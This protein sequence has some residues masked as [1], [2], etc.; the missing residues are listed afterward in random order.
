MNAERSADSQSSKPSKQPDGHQTMN[1]DDQRFHIDEHN[2]PPG[3]PATPAE[4]TSAPL[5]QYEFVMAADSSSQIRWPRKHDGAGIKRVFVGPHFVGQGSTERT[6]SRQ[7]MQG[8]TA[9]AI[10]AGATSTSQLTSTVQDDSSTDSD[11]D[12][13]NG[14]SQD[15][16]SRHKRRRDQR[17]RLPTGE[18][19]HA[20]SRKSS[21]HKWV[22]ESFEIGGDVREAMARRQRRRRRSSES[23]A[24]RIKDSSTFVTARTHQP[25]AAAKYQPEQP[26]P[27]VESHLPPDMAHG[28]L[29]RPSD[30]PI[31]E[32]ASLS[33]A[34][35]PEELA[36]TPDPNVAVTSTRSKH[37]I[38]SGLGNGFP[39]MSTT[40]A[41]SVRSAPLPRP[42]IG[43]AKTSEE[44]PRKA[45][46]KFSNH[47]DKAPRLVGDLPPVPAE[48]VLARPVPDTMVPDDVQM[49]PP[50]PPRRRDDILAKERM[51]CRVDWTVREDLPDL[52]DEH[53]ARKFPTRHEG[54]EEFGV[55][56]RRNRVEL[57]TE[58][59]NPAL[60]LMAGKKKLKHV[61]P[62]RKTQTKLS[63]YSSVDGIFC[64]TH[65]ASATTV[66]SSASR[67]STAT[68]VKVDRETDDE[69]DDVS[70]PWWRKS[71]TKA[72]KR[73]YVHFRHSGTSVYIF[74]AKTMSV[75][76]DWMWQLFIKLGGQVPRSIEVSVP[77]LNA[78]LKAPLPRDLPLKVEGQYL[79]PEERE[80]QGW[81]LLKPSSVIR[82][83]MERLAGIPDFQEVCE[84]YLQG[85]NA[86]VALA[87]R[88]GNFLDW[89]KTG[90]REDDWATICGIALR[91]TNL[92]PVLELRLAMH[93]PT[94][95]RLPA[96]RHEPCIRLCEPPA[97]EGFLMRFRKNQINER[98]YVSSHDGF[99]FICRPSSAH[100]PEPPAPVVQATENPA[101]L[102][103]APFVAGFASL[104]KEPRK[105]DKLVARFGNSR[106]GGG[107][108][109]SEKRKRE[110]ALSMIDKQ[111]EA[112]SDSSNENNL[113]AVF[114]Q[115]EKSRL[116]KQICDARGYIDLR[117]VD[118]VEPDL[119]QDQEMT[120]KITP[121][122]GGAQGLA[123][124]PDKSLRVR[125]R[126]FLVKRKDG[127]VMRF[128]CHSISV[129]EEWVGRLRALVAYWTHR[130]VATARDH[131]ELI[132]PELRPAHP[133]STHTQPRNRDNDA[134]PD[135]MLLTQV[136]HF[137][138]QECCRPIILSGRF[139]VKNGL[140]GIFKER[141]LMLLPGTLIEYQVHARDMFGQPM[142]GTYHRRKRVTSLRG[143]Y[144]YSGRLTAHLLSPHNSST[145]DPADSQEKFS[146]IYPQDKLMVAD[147]EEDCTLVL[148]KR[149]FGGSG[150]FG[151]GGKTY[152]LRARSMIERN[153]WVFA[154]N[155]A[156]EQLGDAEHERETRLKDF[157]WLKDNVS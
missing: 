69:D 142:L 19:V 119:D 46:V 39:P 26:P 137:C 28:L 8:I 111:A 61:I 130:Q 157:G 124:A 100:P 110:R 88:R 22:G 56:L 139:F 126:S 54:F 121:D 122:L 59:R 107:V 155:A 134:D 52:F 43:R 41:S 127:H 101:V 154:L 36:P 90:K 42:I 147:D 81:R 18:T 66:V 118:C 156:I 132:G 32:T 60:S 58:Y 109:I 3:P 40:D 97:V 63:L 152:V 48:E 10:S 153:Q 4:A 146:R 115:A 123:T 136:Y 21:D 76:K 24:G 31:T 106:I 20:N 30:P 6:N 9:T 94:T 89:V 70:R 25:A 68:S 91:Q 80:D 117:E 65:R 72:S 131:M 67:A 125:Q 96:K 50:R 64:L 99:L 23:T 1:D 95:V 73:A 141:R 14:G 12:R 74:K 55:I 133:T 35:P 34:S 98:I 17:S 57:W 135:P 82:L 102:V 105:R 116:F 13:S 75:A 33:A 108:G 144:V 16:Q 87:W 85:G 138:I 71:R 44:A 37:T 103:L 150:R 92:E 86:P 84:E 77:V 120:A 53:N 104:S 129:R 78:K 83:C 128:E 149:S 140:R 27:D 51:L 7:S 11:S 93:A 45:T 151:K 148:F 114:N 143:C 5:Q 145:W 29:R 112:T 47:L 49:P 2:A 15:R 79:W 113:I 62:L 38:P